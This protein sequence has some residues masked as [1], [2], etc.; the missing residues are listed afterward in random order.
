MPFRLRL[1]RQDGQHQ[2]TRAGADLEFGQGGPIEGAQVIRVTAEQELLH[3]TVGASQQI[4]EGHREGSQGRCRHGPAAT[5]VG[6]HHLVG[7]GEQQ[8]ALGLL[9]VG[10]GNQTAVGRHA[11]GAEHH[12]EVG[13]VVGQGGHQ[14]PAAV[15]ARLEK[16]FIQGGVGGYHRQAALFGRVPALTVHLNHQQRHVFPGELFGDFAADTAVAAEDD[17]VI[18]AEKPA[19]ELALPQAPKVAGFRESKDA[20]D[21]D[22]DNH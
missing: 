8:F 1:G 16:G 5:D 19:V 9:A 20:L 2:G 13:G 10:A 4:H 6:T 7:A 22:L 14:G 12:V 11:P 17:M 3:F 21:T 18:H 15:D